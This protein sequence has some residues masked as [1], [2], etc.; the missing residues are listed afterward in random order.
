MAHIKRFPFLRHLR[1]DVSSHIQQFRKGKRIRS[2][3]GPAFWFAPN[4]ASLS[5]VPL[6]DRELP[7]LLVGQSADYQ[8]LTVQGSLVWRVD[9]PQILADRVDFS[10]DLGS[11]QPN[12]QP[13]DQIN[14]VLVSLIRRFTVAYLKEQGVRSLLEAGIAPAQ[15]AVVSGLKGDETL[16]GMGLQL[17]NVTIADVSPSTELARALQA[18][19]FE[20]LQQQADEAMFARRAL[21]VEKERAIA[22]NELGNKIELAARQ[23]QLI[24]REDENSRSRSEAEAAAMKI[25]AAAEADRIRVIGQAEADMEQARMDAYANLPPSMLLALA[26]REFA[27]KLDHIDN[28]SITP[29]MLTNLMAQVRSAIGQPGQVESALQ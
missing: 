1:A 5:E 19:T 24:A 8:D 20:S 16:P 13:I 12:G 29:D 7:F 26:A 21:A 10:I 4:G 27:G 15:E 18:P 17:V 25:S 9:D 22:E 2:G 14:N 11:G 6:D 23:N 3:R 28:L